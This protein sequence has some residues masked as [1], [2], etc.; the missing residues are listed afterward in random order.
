MKLINGMVS[1]ENMKKIIKEAEKQDI[2][3]IGFDG[4]RF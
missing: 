1:I 4:N 3:F 2:E